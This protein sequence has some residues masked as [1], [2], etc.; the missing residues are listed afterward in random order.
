MSKQSALA[1]SKCEAHVCENNMPYEFSDK[2]YME[3]SCKQIK[4]SI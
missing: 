4:S 1:D 3:K 2:N